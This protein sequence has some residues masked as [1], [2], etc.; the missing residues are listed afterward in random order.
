[1]VSSDNGHTWTAK[2]RVCRNYKY[3]YDKETT[4]EKS[5]YTDQMPH[6]ASSTTARLS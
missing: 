3:E 6:S 1:M 4:K 5:I 2:K